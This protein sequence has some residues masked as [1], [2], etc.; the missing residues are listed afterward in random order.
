MPRTVN[1]ILVD[2]T[3]APLGALAPFDAPD[4]WWQDIADVVAAARARHRV[5]VT[6]LRLL[7][8][9]RPAP[10]GGTVTYLAQIDT[11]PDGLLP[12]PA[13]TDLSPDPRRAPWADPGGPDRTLRWAMDRLEQLGR[14]VYRPVQ[15]RAWNLSA[16]WRLDPAGPDIAGADPAGDPVWVKQVPG[17]LAHEAA[18]LRWLGRAVPRLA[19]V[20]LGADGTGRILLDHVPGE[21]RYGAG[22]AEREAIGADQHEIQTRAAADVAALVAAGVPDRRGAALAAYVRRVLTAHGADLA[23][24]AGLLDGLDERLARVADCGVPDTLVHGDLHPGNVRGTGTGGAGGAGGAARVVIDWGDALVGHPAFDVLRLT[25]R[26]D[27][28]VAAALTRSW[29]ARWRASVPGCD[30]ERAL[31][32]LRPVAELRMA[33]VYADFLARI[34][35]AEHPFHAGDVPDHLARAAAL[36]R[37]GGGNPIS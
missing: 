3:G 19:P 11:A 1:L 20:L 7:T 35:P 22:P 6:I 16:I 24:V 21:D 12:V 34:E 32:L 23:P 13:A 30:P 37:K 9:D 2:P 17:F 5:E 26:T 25:E 28:A 15:R 14:G 29:A 8:A 18:V 27:P 36:P 31:D 4:P 33:A 10:P